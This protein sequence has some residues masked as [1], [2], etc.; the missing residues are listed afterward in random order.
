MSE[1]RR[2]RQT[3]GPDRPECSGRLAVVEAQEPADALAAHD[4]SGARVIGW[5]LNE[6][7]IEAL[8]VLCENSIAMFLQ[9]LHRQNAGV[10]QRSPSRRSGRVMV[11]SGV[12]YRRD[13][14]IEQP[15]Q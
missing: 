3:I 7:P 13:A 10:G 2:R 6:P 12:G 15:E 9:E 8:V 4:G 11:G 5:R 1:P 14:G